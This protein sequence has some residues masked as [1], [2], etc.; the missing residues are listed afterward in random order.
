MTARNIFKRAYPVNKGRKSGIK[1]ISFFF[2]GVRSLFYFQFL[3]VIKI[4]MTSLY[5]LPPSMVFSFDI[6]HKVRL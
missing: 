2:F 6:N 3:T 1:I 5:S 4:F